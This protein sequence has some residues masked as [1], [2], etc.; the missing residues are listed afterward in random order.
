[1]VLCH[2][3]EGNLV[4]NSAW[5][6]HNWEI[7]YKNPI[8][9][10][11]A[12]YDCTPRQQKAKRWAGADIGGQERRTVDG[13]WKLD[14]KRVSSLSDRVLGLGCSRDNVRADVDSV[15]RPHEWMEK[16]MRSTFRMMLEN[17]VDS[18]ILRSL[19]RTK[20]TASMRV[21]QRYLCGSLSLGVVSI[22]GSSHEMT[23]ARKLR[24]MAVSL[25]DY[26]VF[27]VVSWIMWRLFPT[28]CTRIFECHVFG[29]AKAHFC[30]FSQLPVEFLKNWQI[31]ENK[32]SNHIN[33]YF[34]EMLR[35]P[36]GFFLF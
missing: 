7:R 13:E 16:W 28:V 21:V 22:H 17:A 33:C 25:A 27:R 23:E 15:E 3:S 9:G 35:I 36:N 6:S 24:F 5:Y 8:P 1:M 32:S 26:A 19:F 14:Q 2:W 12:K 4:L 31:E 29:L 34:R 18:I 20:T 11:E 10:E 30:C